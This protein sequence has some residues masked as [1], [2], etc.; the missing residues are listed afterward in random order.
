[1]IQTFEAPVGRSRT[2]AF[3]VRGRSGFLDLS[4]YSAFRVVVDGPD[5]TDIYTADCP[6]AGADV[7]ARL[8]T[9]E[10]AATATSTVRNG[11]VHWQD[12]AGKPDAE[13]FRLVVFDHA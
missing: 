10:G 3:R 8:V 6:Q 1:M 2:W 7:T 13:R 4:G 9:V 5:G 12:D 11:C